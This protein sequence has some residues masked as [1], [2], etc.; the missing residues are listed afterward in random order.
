[1]TAPA[2]DVDHWP[3]VRGHA[4]RRH[5][6]FQ[7]LVSPEDT[8]ADQT[9]TM[10]GDGYLWAYSLGWRALSQEEERAFRV[11]VQYTAGGAAGLRFLEWEYRAMTSLEVGIGDG[12]GP[13]PLSLP[14]QCRLM[15]DDA[16]AAGLVLA[17]DGVP[18]V[19]GVDYTVAAEVGEFYTAHVAEVAALENILGAVYEASW[20]SA[21]RQRPSVALA[22]PVA[23]RA[24]RR[25]DA[26]SRWMASAELVELEAS[27]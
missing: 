26:P 9:R 2:F 27:L 21:R 5:R 4:Y 7:T 11:A 17:R 10:T 8:A 1:L 13:A 14:L 18:L 6:A 19:L 24:R 25:E 15:D 16:A 23:Y 12:I 20:T 22:S 3:D